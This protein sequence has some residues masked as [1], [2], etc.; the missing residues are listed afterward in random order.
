MISRREFLAAVSGGA[1]ATMLP[2]FAWAA[3]AGIEIPGKAGMIVRSARFLD[4]EM[5]LEFFDSWIT[6]VP[7]FFVRNHMHEPASLDVDGWKLSITGEV[8]TPVNISLAD[9]A[10]LESHAVTNTLECAGN[11]RG[12]QQ[13]KVPGVQWQRGAVGTA[14]FTGPR[15]RDL[16]QRAGVKTTGK[17]VMF[18]GLDEVPGKVPPFIRSIPIEKAID[19]DTLIATHMNGAPLARH[20]GFPARALVPGW[21]GAAS[22]KWL[23]EIKVLSQEF[24]GNFMK[25]GYRMP[26][27]LISPG[28]E[29]NPEDTHPITALGVKSIIAGPSDGSTVK[30]SV[31]IH[32]AAWAGEAAVTRVDISTDGGATWR[33]ARLA[34]Q[35]S[36][37]AWRLWDFVW[38]APKAGEYVVMSRATDDQG[39]TQPQAAAWNPS[40]YLYNAID[41]VKIHVVA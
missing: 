17:H 10:K 4:L 30:S 5:P 3:N 25:P 34:S 13:P 14:R 12:F 41:Q 37:Y 6:P 35:Q 33:G 39:R 38:I 23:A 24:E 15:L 20:H 36:R 11:G 2:G 31:R 27:Q 21:V 8:E 29:V 16:L 40:G 26:N 19:P 32:G 7:H 1:V 18:R 22:C 28:G 9:L